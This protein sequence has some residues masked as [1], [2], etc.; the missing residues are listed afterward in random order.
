MIF[1]KLIVL[2]PF[3]NVR[4]YIID[5]IN[6]L[7]HQ[8]YDSFEVYLLDDNSED[9]TLSLIKKAE[10]IHE[11]RSSK[12]LGA[13]ENIYNALIK[14]PIGDEDI[15]LLLDGDDF[16]FGEY[17]FQI[18]NE[19]YNSNIL[20]TYGQFIDNYGR[21]YNCQ[22]SEKEFK[23]L[24]RSPWKASHLKTFKYKL[25]KELLK[26]DPEGS[27][28]KYD[29]GNFFMAS[30]DMSIMIPLMEIAGFENITAMSNVL[31]CYRLHNNNDHASEE[32]RRLQKEA[33]LCVR[34]R[35]P[36]LK[37]DWGKL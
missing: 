19:K 18:I 11:I 16:I 2:V 35:K 31:Y 1:N 24:R 27:N 9:G 25:F 17:A 21:V 33:E 30:S 5:C 4:N 36:L 28:F 34:N 26:Q 23:N 15:V 37:I 3:R 20:L 22:Y 6:S 14:L 7:L 32:G 29:N 13:M 12:R 10:Y 8:Q